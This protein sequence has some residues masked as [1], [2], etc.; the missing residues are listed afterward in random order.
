[1]ITSRS[2]AKIKEIKKLAASARE[3]REK[4]LFIIEGSR[5]VSEAPAELIEQIYVSQDAG[6]DIKQEFAS[7]RVAELMSGEVFSGISETVSPQGVLALVRQPVHEIGELVKKGFIVILDD[8][9]DPGNLGTIIRTAEAAGAAVL[10]SPGCADVFNPKVVRSTMG[11]IFRVPFICA[12]LTGTVM[13]LK[14]CGFG[15]YAA[16]LEGGADY[17]T[18]Q[19]KD[20][21]AF[22]IGNEANGI[23]QPLLSIADTRIFIPMEGEVESLNAAVS[24]AVLMFACKN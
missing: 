13:F 11:S 1:M 7:V 18:V 15:I 21:A 9:R 12:E 16:A 14:Q 20:K 23:S 6:E 2:N 24:A 10:M 19:Y 8:I 22:I 5:L 3:R 4:G 17:R